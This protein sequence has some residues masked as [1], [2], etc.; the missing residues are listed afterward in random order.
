M[1]LKVMLSSVRRDL[2]DVRDSAA[3]LIDA[4]G[5]E[6][7]RFEDVTTESIPPRAVCV[8]MVERSDI[9]LLLLGG[10]YG[11]PMPDTDMAPTEEEWAVARRLGKPTVVLIREGVEREPRQAEFI[12]RVRSYQDGAWRGTFR[13]IPD[14]LLRLKADLANAAEDIM[15]PVSEALAH[16]VVVPWRDLGSRNVTYRSVLEVVV[17]PLEPVDPVRATSLPDLER[18]VARAG[19][20]HGLFEMD[21]ALRLRSTAEGVTAEV[22]PGGRRTGPGITVSRDHIVTIWQELAGEMGPVVHGPGWEAAIA[23]ALRLADELGVLAGHTVTVA[24][25]L[26]GVAS[27]G[28]VTGPHTRTMPFVGRPDPLVLEPTRAYPRG[29]LARASGDIARELVAELLLRLPASS[30]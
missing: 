2:A 8:Q 6:C 22:E 11:D 21:E 17:L 23:R 27:L 29:R 15:G 10:R 9:Y 30:P 20:D 7:V 16:P 4:L 18:L 12:T 28:V 3:A 13:D 14:L 1:A 19:Q 24:I 5:Y 26:V 25:R